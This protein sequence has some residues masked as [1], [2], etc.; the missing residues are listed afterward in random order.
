[1]A[2]SGRSKSVIRNKNVRR[3]TIYGPVEAERIMRLA[4]K[5]G[6]VTGQIPAQMDLE[7]APNADDTAASD[8]MQIEK[9][10]T[11][12]S[13]RKPKINK[14]YNY[15]NQKIKKPK[16]GDKN[17]RFKWVPQKR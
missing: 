1:M 13:L 6:V 7:T 14:R 10:S 17:G 3:A 11:K 12:V 8:E 5:Q 15:K 4:K 16:H 2:K 9:T